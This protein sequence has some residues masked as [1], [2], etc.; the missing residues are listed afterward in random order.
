MISTNDNYS[1]QLTRIWTKFVLLNKLN[2]S[3]YAEV[4]LEL[5][6]LAPAELG[7]FYENQ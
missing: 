4:T 7:F 3:R 5:V 1:L 2:W 6:Q